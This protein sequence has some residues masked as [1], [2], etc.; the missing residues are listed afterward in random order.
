MSPTPGLPVQS[1]TPRLK[2]TPAPLRRRQPVASPASPLRR[3][4]IHFLLIFVTVVLV[5]DALVGEKGF[6]ETM[7]ARRQAR[8]QE[9][10]VA[11]LRQENAQLR[12]EA[13]RLREDPKAI[14][15]VAREELGLIRPGELLFILK[16]TKPAQKDSRAALRDRTPARGAPHSR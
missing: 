11:R 5:V 15:S 8:E 14:E 7:R 16:D 3:K 13:R 10:Q 2:R 1:D 9:A 12:D 4:V 6:M